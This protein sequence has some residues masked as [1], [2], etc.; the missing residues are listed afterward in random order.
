VLLQHPAVAECAVVGL[1]D[2]ARGMIVTAVVVLHEG[3][4]GDAAMTEA[5]QNHVKSMIAPYKYPRLVVYRPSLPKTATG[6]L[7]RYVLRDEVA[8]NR[9]NPMA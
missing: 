1:A 6:K 7:Q 2:A 4:S 5:L 3:F 8:A 9:A